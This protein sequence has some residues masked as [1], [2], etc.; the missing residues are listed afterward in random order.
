MI[1]F[2]QTSDGFKLYFKDYFFF[3][4]SF[5]NPCFKIGT[6]SSRFKMRHGNFKIKEK[7]YKKI[8]LLN[9]EVIS[10]SE[11]IIELKF[12]NSAH[13]LKITFKIVNDHLEVVPE[14]FDT[15]INRFWVSISANANEA[16]YGC[17]EQFSELNLRS[18]NVPLWVQEQGIGR[19]DPSITG[20]WYTTY[21]PQPTFVSSENYY[22][23]IE[24]SSYS[25]LNFTEENLHELYI[26][27]IPKK[28][29]IG[30][31]NTALQVI[32]NLS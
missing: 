3:N 21:Y 17:G 18:K 1:K 19:G 31:Y 15:N 26:W 7:L 13:K 23:H 20:N 22:Y 14:C 9:Y 12:N 16:I 27:N 11:K 5:K 2:E 24:T 29:L 8:P 30:K 32:K 4:H 10:Q 25:E 6:G 28:I